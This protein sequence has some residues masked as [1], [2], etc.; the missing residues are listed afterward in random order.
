[1]KHS[2]I[3][4]PL[5]ILSL[6]IFLLLRNFGLLPAHIFSTLIKLWPLLLI[7]AGLEHL[8]QNSWLSKVIIG[9]IAIISACFL[10]APTLPLP[11]IFPSLPILS[12]LQS[13]TRTQDFSFTLKSSDFPSTSLTHLR[14]EL[15][16]PVATINIKDTTAL[17]LVNF[18]AQN[19]L[20]Q[21]Q[22]DKKL[23]NSTLSIRMSTPDQA[24]PNLPQVNASTQVTLG[25]QEL[26]TQID[27]SLGVGSI[28]IHLDQTPLTGLSA[29]VGTGSI[30]LQ[31]GS[32]TLP[33]QPIT[34]DTGVGSIHLSLSS[35]I[36]YQL[37]YDSGLGSI[38]VPGTSLSGSGTYTSTNFTTADQTIII[39][40]HTGLGSINIS[41]N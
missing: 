15:D 17:H 2:S 40:A 11:K 36:G 26:P 37:H 34:L 9:L 29:K 39:H 13:A 21:P 5:I 19:F 38:Q 28:Q 33:R 23:D 22:V 7:F 32:Q 14:L 25:C 30:H 8:L 41:R 20:Q 18:L 31:L 6:G 16:L 10:L 27:L 12:R 35:S 24:G 4:G 1:M 3:T